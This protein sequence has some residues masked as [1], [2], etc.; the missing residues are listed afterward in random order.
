MMVEILIRRLKE[1]LSK[2]YMLDALLADQVYRRKTLFVISLL[3]E[4]ALLVQVI[5]LRV[6]EASRLASSPLQSPSLFSA[7]LNFS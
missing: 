4:G 1:L 6:Q 3:G 2:D 5:S 7:S